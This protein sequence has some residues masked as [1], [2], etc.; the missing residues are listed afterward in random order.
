MKTV[1]INTQIPTHRIAEH[2]IKPSSH[3][4]SSTANPCLLAPA[5]SQT[6]TKIPTS[7]GAALLLVPR[8]FTRPPSVATRSGHTISL[9]STNCH[10]DHAKS[11]RSNLPPPTIKIAPLVIANPAKRDEATSSITFQYHILAFFI[12][13]INQHKSRL[14]TD[15]C[16]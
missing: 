12:L 13:L 1:N 11:V 2:C 15:Y 3:S 4:L 5:G 6:S 9:R 14:S 7:M 10:C 16:K 8:T